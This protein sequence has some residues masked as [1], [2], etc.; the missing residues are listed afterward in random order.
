MP[1]RQRRGDALVFGRLL[2][3]VGGRLTLQ[4][5]KLGAEQAT[6]FSSLR[7][8]ASASA[9]EP[10]L[11]STSIRVPV[12]CTTLHVAPSLALPPGARAAC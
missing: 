2:G 12:G 1:A 8:A 10:T 9:T 6:A 7:T 5:K 3:L 4:E 11:A